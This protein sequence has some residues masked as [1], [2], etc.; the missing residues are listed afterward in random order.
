MK[1]H[2]WVLLIAFIAALAAGW[3]GRDVKDHLRDGGWLA[4]D[5][6]SSRA[7]EV[8]ARDFGAGRPNLILLA[9]AR[10][11]VDTAEARTAGL[12]LTE[13]LRTTPGLSD[14][15]SYWSGNR[16]LRSYDGTSALVLARSSGEI[17][18][19]AGTHGPLEVTVGGE[20]QVSREITEQ[21]GSDLHNAELLVLPLTVLLLLFVFGGALAVTAPVVVGAVAVAGTLAVLR[22]LTVFTDVSVFALNI[23]TA[24]GFALAVDYSLFIVSRYREELAEGRP[25]SAAIERSLRTAGRTVLFSAITVMLSLAGLLVFPLFFLR[26]LAFAGITVVGLAAVSALVVLPAL[27]AVIGTRITRFDLFAR[28]RR[29]AP[30]GGWYRLA[31]TVMRRPVVIAVPVTLVLIALAV[32]FR[33]VTFG[34]ADHRVLPASATA[35]QVMDTARTQFPGGD[36][37]QLVVVLPG[38]AP[39]AELDQYVRALPDVRTAVRTGSAGTWLSVAGQGDVVHRVRSVASP[40]PALVGGPAAQVADTKQAI[41]DKLPWAV[42]IVLLTTLVLLFL[43]TGSVF[44]PVKAVVLNLLS[45]SAPF[46]A[47]VYVFQEGN[48]RWLVGDFAITGTTNLLMPILVFCIAFGLSM[49]Y[50][51]LLLSRI[52]EEYL[53]GADT[54]G[55]T[56]AGLARTGRLF[57]ASAALVATV[58]GGLV[59]SELAV[60]KL[61]GFGLLLAVLIDATL[62]RCLLVPAVMRLAGRANWWCPRPLRVLHERAGVVH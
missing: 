39:G 3:A 36:A 10:G 57:T 41:G 29:S 25:V 28:W 56:A 59:V 55:A 37:E 40:V 8:L 58:L 26:S 18:Q 45:L 38:L 32:P 9:R 19:V 33:S 15:D 13:R 5:A 14:V 7:D 4:P 43:F 11:S 21:S 42:G 27:L 48:L 22:V 49:D 54:R 34:L 35:H 12:R 30:S 1:R 2:H 62:V 46:G 23:T 44:I 16:A 20:L 50:E 47:I 53:A 24:L 61:L 6:E 52:R 51:V 31:H 60:L 17:P